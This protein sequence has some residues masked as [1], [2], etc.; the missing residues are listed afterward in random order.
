MKTIVAGSRGFKN[1]SII[2]HTLLV[3]NISEIVSGTARGVDQLGE[4]FGKQYN[5]PIKKNSQLIGINM[6]NLL[7]ILEM[8]K[9]LNMLMYL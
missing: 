5:I 4:R 9:W 2:R 7:V 6:V 3:Y 8:K 1:Y